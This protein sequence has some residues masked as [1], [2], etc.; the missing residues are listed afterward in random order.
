MLPYP[1]E[2][3]TDLQEWLMSSTKSGSF[4]IDCRQWVEFVKMKLILPTMIFE[5]DPPCHETQL[6]IHL[7]GFYRKDVPNVNYLISRD[8][9][10]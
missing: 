9:K 7:I 2:R 10:L 6:Y 5:I 8:L 3:L 4:S 1:M